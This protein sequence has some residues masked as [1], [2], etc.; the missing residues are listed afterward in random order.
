MLPNQ[1]KKKLLLLKSFYDFSLELISLRNNRI[2]KTIKFKTENKILFKKLKNT[3]KRFT[4]VTNSSNDTSLFF[5]KYR[6]MF[7]ADI[8]PV[9]T[10]SSLSSSIDFISG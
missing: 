4:T 2:S 5:S 3:T 6:P 10:N 1:K 9:L 8:Y 7:W